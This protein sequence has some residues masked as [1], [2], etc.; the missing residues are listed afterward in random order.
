MPTTTL[1]TFLS[2]HLSPSKT[3]NC[4][5]LLLIFSWEIWESEEI[6]NLSKDIGKARVEIPD[7]KTCVHSFK[8]IVSNKVVLFFWTQ[9]KFQLVWGKCLQA[10][11]H[12]NNK[13]TKEEK[14][15]LAIITNSNKYP[16]CPKYSKIFKNHVVPKLSNVALQQNKMEH[17]TRNEKFFTTHELC[18]P[19]CWLQ[20][21][22]EQI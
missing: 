5:L 6:N 17:D 21:Y 14:N 1:G 19:R 13:C 20:N 7:S 9:G 4:A 16:L 3:E 15:T 8:P 22:S 10:K 12:K 11:H 2:S 18:S